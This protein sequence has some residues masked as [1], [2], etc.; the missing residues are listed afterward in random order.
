MISVAV[1]FTLASPITFDSTTLLLSLV[2]IVLLVAASSI[3]NQCLERATDGQMKRTANRPLPSR[4]ITITEAASV[5]VSCGISGCILLYMTTNPATAIA[6]FSTL[7]VYVFGYTLLK[8]KSIWC[9]TVGA[10]P[11]AM[12]PV[13]GWLAAGGQLGW[14]VFS[15]FA[16]F[17][18]WQFPHFLAIGW[19]HRNDYEKA[20]LKMLPSFKDDGLSTGL[21]AVFY[22]VLFVPVAMSP[23]WLGLTGLPY[24]CVAAALSLA[25]LW[26]SVQFLRNRT[27][28]TARSLLYNSLLA[29]PILLVVLMADYLRIH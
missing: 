23:T 8:P 28:Q 10:V 20:G 22:A 3:L 6:G 18:V 2:G 27:D 11:G 9:T 26:Y 12:P 21:G 16:I 1:G 4:R 14:E 13:L 5:G 17:F 25:Y 7:I 15:L 29:L 24:L 19:K